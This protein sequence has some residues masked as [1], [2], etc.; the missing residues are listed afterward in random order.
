MDL[1]PYAPMEND[2]PQ[3]LSPGVFCCI[4]IVVDLDHLDWMLARFDR[5]F[6]GRGEISRIDDG[7][8]DKLGHGFVVLEW[9]ECTIDPLFIAI[10][11]DEDRVLDFTMYQ[12]TEDM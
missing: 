9:T 2:S 12:R 8:S 10:L 11:K 4:H 7:N 5:W 1:I 3:T 6:D